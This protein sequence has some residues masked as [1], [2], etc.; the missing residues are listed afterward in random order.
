[1]KRLSLAALAL[2]LT[3]LAHA[4]APPPTPQPPPAAPSNG[5]PAKGQ[6]TLV[7][8]A[9][10]MTVFAVSVDA[11][12]LLTAIAEKAGIKLVVDDTVSRKLTI[13]LENRSASE[14]IDAL[15]RAYGLSSAEVDGVRMISEGIPRTPSSYLLSDIA[16]IPTKYVAAANA[17]NL[18]PVFLQD[19]V[20]V[21]S[22]Q[23]AVVL[24][25]PTDILSKFK[26]DIAQFD[27]PAAQILVDLLL[28]ELTDTTADALGLNT[29]WINAS[30]GPTLDPTAGTI[31][32]KAVTAL[33]DQFSANLKALVDSG[34]ARV[35]ANPRIATVSGRPASIFVGRQRYIAQ[36]ISSGSY[37]SESNFIDAGVRLNITPYTGGQ[38]NVLIRAN[39]EVSTLSAPDPTTNL[40]EKST[41][42]AETEVRVGDGQ[43]LIIGGL[44]QQETR[45][46][47]TKV[48]LLGDIPVLGPLFFQSKD[49]RTSKTELLLFITPRILSSTGHLPEAEEKKL[50]DRFLNVPLSGKKR[51]IK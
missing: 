9:K 15:V 36:P 51:D 44:T 2:T 40:P 19:Y 32:Y 33:P 12:E 27:I 13:Q 29:T 38:G 30:E 22:D 43:T 35:R 37:G 39:A 17:R 7:G 48:P 20:R 10:K 25:G 41:R 49:V 1:M 47:R 14:A 18:L 6:F 23:N 8:D 46:V 31:S 16:T 45:D 11:P 21:N 5:L 42:K 24:S 34:K 3:P 4:Q 50:K 26:D 28:V